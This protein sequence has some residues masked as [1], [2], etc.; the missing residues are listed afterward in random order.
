MDHERRRLAEI[1]RAMIARAT[2][3]AYLIDLDA[4]DLDSLRDL[5][6]FLRDVEH[7]KQQAAQQ[8]RLQPWR[9]V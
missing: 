8:A 5:Q 6:R 3:R 7:E 4:L 1:V 9:R 2:G